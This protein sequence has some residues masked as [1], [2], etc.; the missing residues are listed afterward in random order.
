MAI[1]AAAVAIPF[2]SHAEPLKTWQGTALGAQATLRLAHPDA[3]AIAKQVASEIS[4][5]EDIFS[6]YR[7]D[8]A[9]PR[10]NRSGSLANPPFELLECLSLAGAVHRAS[11]GRFDP[12]IQPLWASYAEAFALGT[13]PTSE[14]LQTARDLTG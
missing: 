12:T 5:L 1:S 11:E 2:Q 7:L 3:K 10:L 13:P 6:L 9:V 14:A 8:S 4:R